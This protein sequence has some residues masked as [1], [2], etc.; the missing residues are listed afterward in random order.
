MNQKE[1]ITDKLG[2]TLN[3]MQEQAYQ[4]ISFVSDKIS[5]E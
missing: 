3:E 4:T 1:Q 5:A 2:I